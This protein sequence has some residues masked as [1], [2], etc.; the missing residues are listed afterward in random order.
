MKVW[1]QESSQHVSNVDPPIQEFL[2][3]FSFICHEEG[4]FLVLNEYDK[5]TLCPMW[6]KCYK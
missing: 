4:K 1:G 5:N 6:L 2:L 3:V